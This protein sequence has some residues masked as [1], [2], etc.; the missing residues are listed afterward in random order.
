MGSPAHPRQRSRSPSKE[1]TLAAPREHTR[2]IQPEPEPD[3]ECDSDDS[4]NWAVEPRT[5]KTRNECRITMPSSPTKD[6]LLNSGPLSRRVGYYEQ[7][8]LY[9]PLSTGS[10]VSTQHGSRHDGYD[11]PTR[12][13][14][15]ANP[16]PLRNPGPD[17]VLPPL[18]ERANSYVPAQYGQ[19]GNQGFPVRNPE[20]NYV[21]PPLR[22]R[23]N[24]NIPAQHGHPGNQG[25]PVRNPE[26]VYIPPPISVRAPYYVPAQ[27]G[28]HANQAP[29]RNPEPEHVPLRQIEG[30]GR[31]HRL[32]EAPSHT[33]SRHHR[34]RDRH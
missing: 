4:F 9:P 6:R 5:M 22:E 1:R 10:R 13:D 30:S 7:G 15:Y 27:H 20:A 21:P 28:Q 32:L 29:I 12:H 2:G 18:R 23:T 16:V 19:P 25:F 34:H 26:L 8:D 3:R 31:H 17:Y 11:V 33:G 14:Q 24:Y